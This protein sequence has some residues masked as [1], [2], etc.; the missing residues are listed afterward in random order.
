MGQYDSGVSLC[1]SQSL[2]DVYQLWQRGV[3]SLIL[4][5]GVGEAGG[6]NADTQA[7]EAA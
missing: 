6:A 2:A 4:I 7:P 5:M 1:A 3:R